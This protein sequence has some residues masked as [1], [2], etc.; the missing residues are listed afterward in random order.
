MNH[1]LT[2]TSV[3]WALEE[4]SSRDDQVRL[5]LSDG[6]SG[7]V[8]SFAEAICGVFDGGVSKELES[9]K[10]AANL[11][12]SFGRLRALVA[13][14]PTDIPPQELIDHPKMED[15]RR[16]SLELIQQL[17]NDKE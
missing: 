4:L 2:R 6:S 15:I 12:S 11:K 5:W 9:E 13:T 8:S 1:M 17:R 3:I 14:I 7:E 10:V 16:L